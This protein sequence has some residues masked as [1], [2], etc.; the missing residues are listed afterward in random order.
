MIKKKVVSGQLLLLTTLLLILNICD[1]ASVR[2]SDK[3]SR[4]SGAQ[5]VF[6][7]EVESDIELVCEL[8]QANKNEIKWRRINGVSS[9][10][11]LLSFLFYNII[12]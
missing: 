7:R 5:M 4:L 10:S 9:L 3:Q 6:E 8:S 11:L 12:N 2:K 1:A